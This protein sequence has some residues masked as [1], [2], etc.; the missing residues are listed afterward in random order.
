MD[1]ATMNI[2]LS[3]VLAQRNIF[4]FFSALLSIAVILLAC[5]LFVR[6]ERVVILPTVGPSLWIEENRVSDTYLEKMGA[7]LGDLLLTK[8]PSDVER[9]NKILLEYVHPSF[10]QEV[11]KQLS[12][13]KDRIIHGN[14]TILFRPSRSFIDPI[15]NTYTMEGKLLIFVGKM[16]ETPS[17]A[18]SDEKRFTFEFQCE[19]GKLLLK[20]LKQEDIP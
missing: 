16:G 7:Y 20:S 9:K 19:R 5:L 12:H 6:K 14:Q 8:T 10:Y 18:Q 4:L 15:Q 1:I 17:C 11:K 2:N 3:K 13:E